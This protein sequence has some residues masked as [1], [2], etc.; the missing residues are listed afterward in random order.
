ML[1][2]LLHWRSLCTSPYPNVIFPSQMI[3]DTF[4]LLQ[5]CCSIMCLWKREFTDHLPT[6]KM[7]HEWIFSIDGMALNTGNR[8]TRREIWPSATLP[9]TN[10]TWTDLGANT[11]FRD[12]KPEATNSLSYVPTHLKKMLLQK[13]DSIGNFLPL[14][15]NSPVKF[16]ILFVRFHEIFSDILK[17]KKTL[18]ATKQLIKC[19]N[20]YKGTA[21]HT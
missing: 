14:S 20:K 10:S 16:L 1:L 8:R 5:R 15:C 17:G 12:E 13:P 19:V 6:S 4:F 11:D 7:I 3:L 21:T 18:T 2:I 9:T